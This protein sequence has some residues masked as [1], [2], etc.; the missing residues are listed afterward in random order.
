MNRV[1][2]STKLKKNLFKSASRHSCEDFERRKRGEDKCRLATSLRRIRQIHFVFY[3]FSSKRRAVWRCRRLACLEFTL[4]Q[5]LDWC[6][7]RRFKAFSKGIRKFYCK[8]DVEENCRWMRL[9][10]HR[11]DS[12][13]KWKI[14]ENVHQTRF[15]RSW[16]TQ[17]VRADKQIKFQLSSCYLKDNFK[18]LQRL[19]KK[20][21]DFFI[22]QARISF[23]K[24]IFI[25][26][27]LRA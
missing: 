6:S 9:R 15:Q 19:N 5:W 14:S 27:S 21:L 4:R 18:W 23:D 2:C 13:S 3:W 8:S 1:F 7:R 22:Y 16:P 17:L 12:T 25:A 10:R 26:L 11:I 24:R 20:F